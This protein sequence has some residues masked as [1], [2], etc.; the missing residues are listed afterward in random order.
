MRHSLTL[1]SADGSESVILS[2]PTTWDDVTL[3]QYIDWQCSEEPAVCVLA[4][5]SQQQLDR[6]AW[7]DAQ[8]LLNLLAFAAETPEP[9]VSEGLKD[10]GSATYGQLV[11]ANQYF[12]EH[13]DKPTIWYAPYIYALYRCREV[14]GRN[15]QGKEA[16]MHQAILQEPVGKCLSNVLFMYA[17]WLSSTNVMLATPRTMPSPARKNTTPAWRSFLTALGKPFKPMRLPAA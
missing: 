16:E 8:Y 13:P 11:L 3:Q 2:V 9:P 14:W 10:P 15:D 17:S 6:L 1:T 4:G 12:E 5:I 7:L